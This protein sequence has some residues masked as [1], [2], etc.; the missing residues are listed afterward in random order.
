MN[1]ND[2]KG[3][4]AS[5]DMKQPSA[6]A[7]ESGKKRTKPSKRSKSKSSSSSKASK[8]GKKKDRAT[9][10][11][12]GKARD[13]AAGPSEK[14]DAAKKSKPRQEKGASKKSTSSSG[15]RSKSSKSSKKG[16]KGRKRK[17]VFRKIYMKLRGSSSK[18]K[19]SKRKKSAKSEKAPKLS[20]PATQPSGTSDARQPPPDASASSS[21]LPEQAP[22]ESAP[23][24]TDLGQK[25]AEQAMPDQK[26]PEPKGLGEKASDLATVEEKPVE[27]GVPS[28]VPADH[29]KASPAHAGEASVSDQ[30]GKSQDQKAPPVEK[31]DLGKVLQKDELVSATQGEEKA[32]GTPKEPAQAEHSGALKSPPPKPL[33]LETQEATPGHGQAAQPRA[34][35]VDGGRQVAAG[36]SRPREEVIQ[37]E[38]LP[39]KDEERPEAAA[40]T[41][42]FPCPETDVEHGGA[43]SVDWASFQAFLL[44]EFAAV[45]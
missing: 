32:P 8:S 1:A 3:K 17:S 34:G 19:K 35:A 36:A 42:T 23:E 11:R 40:G 14:K 18:S 5:K 29:A 16:G 13:L 37:P 38:R 21:T 7:K 20:Q 28:S 39:I 22:K 44:P 6:K 26:G 24:S 15:K 41:A 33:R 31:E 30:V 12:N 25:T 43:I 4:Q 2:D 9:K 27:S 45:L 10:K